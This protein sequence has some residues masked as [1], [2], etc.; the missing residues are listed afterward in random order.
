MKNTLIDSEVCNKRYFTQLVPACVNNTAGY[1]FMLTQNGFNLT[2]FH[3]V[4]PDFNLEE[5]EKILIGK[6]LKRYGNNKK[7]TAQMLGINRA[8]L[9]NKMRRH[10]IE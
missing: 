2:H 10:G 3:P 1:V 6:A 9:Y 4:T 7:L 8:T 5:N